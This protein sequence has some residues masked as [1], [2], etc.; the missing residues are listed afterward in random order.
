[1]AK[2]N[3]VI[4]CLVW[5]IV[6]FP[7]SAGADPR[8][9]KIYFDSARDLASAGRY[10][11]AETI[12]E[13]AFQFEPLY[14][15]ALYLKAVIL[16]EKGR[17]REAANL[18]TSA[19]KAGNWHSYSS[20]DGTVLAARILADI[21][22][23]ADA[24]ELLETSGSRTGREADSLLIRIKCLLGLKERGKALAELDK[25]LE[26]FPEDFRFAELSFRTRGIG[27]GN[28]LFLTRKR[29]NPEYLAALLA[30]IEQDGPVEEKLALAEEYYR[31]GGSSPRA[32]CVILESGK[33]DEKELDRFF[34]KGGI[35]SLDLIRRAVLATK[36]KARELL[37]SRLLSFSGPM[38][39]DEDFDGIP[40]ITYRVRGGEVEEFALDE[41]QDGTAEFSVTFRDGSPAKV[42]LAG[43]DFVFTADYSDYPFVE[44]CEIVSGGGE[45]TTY[46]PVP[47]RSASPL[48]RNLPGSTD[49]T[50]RLLHRYRIDRS[51]A[52]P[53][54]EDMRRTAYKI[55]VSVPSSPFLRRYLVKGG[56]IVKLE[57]IAPGG[58]GERVRRRVDFS[59]GKP[60]LGERDLD[61]DGTFDLREIYS[62]GT[63]TALEFGKNP[64]PI[65]REKL[66]PVRMKEWDVNGDGLIDAKE[67]RNGPG[68]VR[69][70]STLLDGVFDAAAVD[71]TRLW[72]PLSILDGAMKE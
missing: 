43:K 10:A 35:S 61:M 28:G 55:E 4:V 5:I 58:S 53:D 3:A 57:E 56:E 30:Y 38:T 69:E 2:R 19:I 46:F 26:M 68:R 41:D 15:D 48:I 36:G 42:F 17:R 24:A 70:F 54:P 1:M 47:G 11:E 20:F 67:Y 49:R 51:F 23:Y 66:G 39:I 31:L 37:E 21:R 29:S 65:Y 63:L 25:A 7:L 71:P 9:A 59:D 62:N 44:R 32:S 18:A 16:S 64:N 22:R 50:E 34:A 40:E 72:K 52:L 12:L 27:P 45:K 14:S 8:F 13:T 60:L 33:A 6:L